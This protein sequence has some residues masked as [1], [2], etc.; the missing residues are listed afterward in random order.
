MSLGF[1][2]I[3]IIVLVILLIFGA[4]RIPRIMEDIAKGMKA[5]KK[6]LT[7]DETPSRTKKAKQ[8]P[9]H[10]PKDLKKKTTG[11]SKRK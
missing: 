11:P 9:D 1:G 10:R 4:G 7:E 5:F 3:V 8:L 6:G 2:Q